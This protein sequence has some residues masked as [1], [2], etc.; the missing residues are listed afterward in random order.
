MWPARLLRSD[1]ARCRPLA[2]AMA[3]VEDADDVGGFVERK[4]HTADLAKSTRYA[5]PARSRSKTCR[6]GFVRPVFTSAN[7]RCSASMVST[8]SRSS[9]N[10]WRSVVCLMKWRPGSMPDRAHRE[11]EAERGCRT[12]CRCAPGPS[13]LMLPA[14]ALW[15]PP[16]R[17]LPIRAEAV[18]EEVGVEGEDVLD[19]QPFQQ[20]ERGAVGETE[21]LIRKRLCDPPGGF[22][23]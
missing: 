17:T 8:R 16:E 9:R 5:M 2:R 15:M 6:A 20:G 10:N 21:I 22:E 14:K 13:R 4:K 23:V 3:D 1:L 18:D 19:S 12:S 11:E 7:P